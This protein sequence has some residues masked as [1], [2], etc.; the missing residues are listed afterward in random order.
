LELPLFNRFLP[1]E[2]FLH[3]PPLDPPQSGIT[4]SLVVFKFG[5][6]YNRAVLIDYP[7]EYGDAIIVPPF[8]S[9]KRGGFVPGY[10]SPLF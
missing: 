9:Y 1:D 5:L 10:E 2:S 4:L 6:I 8:T 7:M 3:A